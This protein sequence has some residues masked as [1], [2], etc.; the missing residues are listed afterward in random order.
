[1]RR[2][3]HGRG[4]ASSQ[5]RLVADQLRGKFPKLAELMDGAEHNVLAFMTFPKAHRTQFHRTNPLEGLNA[6]IKRRTDVVGIGWRRC[7]QRTGIAPAD[8]G[9]DGLSVTLRPRL[10]EPGNFTHAFRR[11][12]GQTLLD[13]ARI[14]PRRDAHDARSSSSIMVA[15][16]ATVRCRAGAGIAWRTGR[17]FVEGSRRSCCIEFCATPR[18]AGWSLWA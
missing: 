16:T 15:P 10:A 6:E 5:W 9:R 14:P 12:A 11:W 17:S 1:L 4:P 8:L 2:Q 18:W 7:L 3:P 13:L